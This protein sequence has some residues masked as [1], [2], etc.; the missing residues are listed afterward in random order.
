VAELQ[1][2][3]AC[4]I[5]AVALQAEKDLVLF[6]DELERQAKFTDSKAA[7][8]LLKAEEQRHVVRIREMIDAWT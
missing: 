1:T 2:V 4:D 6:Y 7:F 8:A 5:L 3:W